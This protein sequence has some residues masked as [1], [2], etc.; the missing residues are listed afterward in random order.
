MRHIPVVREPREYV[1]GAPIAPRRQDYV[2]WL[3]LAAVPSALLQATTSR[4]TQDVGSMPFLWMVPLALYL[5]TFILAFE[6]PRFYVRHV[7]TLAIALGAAAAVPEWSPRVTLAVTFGMLALTGLGFHGEL[8]VRAPAPAWLTRF[9][10]VVSAGG[11]LGSAG[12]ALG[13]PLLF[14]GV[15]EYPLT[16]SAAM[17]VLAVVYWSVAVRGSR[18]ADRAVRI[19]ADET[20][21]AE[22]SEDAAETDVDTISVVT[23]S[24]GRG[25]RGIAVALVFLGLFIAGK[26]ALGWQALTD[27]DVFASRNF[28]GAVRVREETTDAGLLQRRLQHGTTLHGVQ[29]VGGDKARQPISYYTPSSGLGQAMASL[30]ALGRP[31]RIG[32]VGLGTGTTAAYGR[33]GDDMT[34]FEIDPQFVA[35]STSPTPLFTY[36]RDSEATIHIVGGDARLSL[37]RASPSRFDLL[38]LDAFSSDAVPVHLLTR[39]AV[40]LYARHL[41][42][43]RSLLVIHV[44]NRYLDLEGVVQAAGRAAGF[45]T[46][47]VDDDVV[48]DD[49]E[50]TTWMVLARDPE[51]LRLFGEPLEG[52][53]GPLWT[54]ASSNL[55]SVLRRD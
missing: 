12:V 18:I 5:T 16:L 19:G 39:E 47:Q 29:Y 21:R 17:L 41:R 26:T 11:V 50:R 28:F 48:D 34:I 27:N 38:V 40:Q 43:A 31:A 7:L 23:T 32:V 45:M 6:F 20:R 3:L 42:D 14:N 1:D 15:L 24:T 54:D 8:A 9:F 52:E 49:S 30:A 53:G 36:L 25:M 37:E 35:L 33:A 10:L 55:L 46:V 13:A 44:S 2:L 22:R 51:A 4:I